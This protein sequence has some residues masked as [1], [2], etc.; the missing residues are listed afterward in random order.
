MKVIDQ[1]LLINN[2]VNHP[3]KSNPEYF[4]KI[5]FLY[6]SD[7]KKVMS[8]YWEA[9]KGWFDNEYNGFDEINYII[10]GEIELIFK[11][12]SFTVKKGDCFL[13]KKGEN[14][15][16]KIKKNSK[17]FLFIY[18]TD[19]KVMKDIRKMIGKRNGIIEE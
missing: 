2:L 15:K 10:D 16:F 5:N 7:D 3:Y 18:P 4:A 13:I 14:V 6:L 19:K 12:K 11:D 1:N 9:P 8:A 17:T